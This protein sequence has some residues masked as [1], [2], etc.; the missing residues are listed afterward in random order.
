MGKDIFFVVDKRLLTDTG[1]TDP[2]HP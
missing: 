2:F 1:R